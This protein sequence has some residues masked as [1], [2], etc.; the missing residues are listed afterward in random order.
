MFSKYNYNKYINDVL[1]VKVF[2]SYKPSKPLQMQKN[3]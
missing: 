2:P 3:V 1:Y